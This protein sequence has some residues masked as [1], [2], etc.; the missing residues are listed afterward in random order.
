[1]CRRRLEPNEEN[2]SIKELKSVSRVGSIETAGRCTAIQMLLADADRE[3]VC[4]AL[5][6][7]E[8]AVRKW[9]KAS[10][11][12]G[13]DELIVNKR[14]GRK[15]I[16]ADRS[17]ELVELIEQPQRAGR[18]FWTAKSFH[19]YLSDHYELELSYRTMV[20]FFHSQGYRLKVPSPGQ[21][22]K[23]S[24]SGRSLG[25]KWLNY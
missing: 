15:A 3:V 14:P 1:M 4:K 9:I 18:T 16:L 21:N 2:G 10:N 20:R 17:Q 6:V 25:T 8:R 23:T 7:S 13:V 12:R 19:G 22:V 24:R 5:M 11:A